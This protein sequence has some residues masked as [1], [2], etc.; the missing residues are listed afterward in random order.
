M[1]AIYRIEP[2]NATCLAPPGDKPGD[3]PYIDRMDKPADPDAV[4]LIYDGQCPVCTAYSGAV[5]PE[6]A[7]KL[8]RID[9]RSDDPLVRAA[10]AAGYDLDEGMIVMHAGRYYHGAEALSFMARRAPAKG[11]RNRLHRLLLGSSAVSRT[12]YPALRAGRNL[13]LKLLGRKK[14]GAVDKAA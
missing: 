5:E 13:L 7:E 8:E 9:A 6:G 2:L 14:I 1:R 12:V 4:T 11:L 3:A 10:T